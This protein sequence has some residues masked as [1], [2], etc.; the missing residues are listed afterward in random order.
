VHR[1]RVH[2]EI[3]AHQVVVE[4]VAETHLRVAGYAVVAVGPE[5]GDL[6]ALVVLLRADRAE[7]D[8]GIPQRVGPRPQQFLQLLRAGVGGE[9]Q[10]GDRPLQH[11]VAHRA[12][13][14]IQLVA[15]GS[16]QPAEVAQDVGMP[17]QCDRGS[18]QQ[19]G[20]L[21]SVGHG[22]ERSRTT[23]R[24]PVAAEESDDLSGVGRR[25]GALWPLRSP[26]I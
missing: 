21:G 22:T 3:A 20:I 7:L 12:A 23:M 13:D 25:C 2:G 19:L 14:Q 8:A 6:Q 16:E 11:R 17:V 1:H 26:T 4:G 24:R 18:G 9:V 15:G 5:R 10:I